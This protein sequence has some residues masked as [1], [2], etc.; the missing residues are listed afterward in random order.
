[1]KCLRKSSF[2]KFLSSLCWNELC[3]KDHWLYGDKPLSCTSCTWRWNWCFSDCSLLQSVQLRWLI[4]KNC[5]CYQGFKNIT[6]CGFF[7]S[8]YIVRG[9]IS[10]QFVWNLSFLL[11]QLLWEKKKKSSWSQIYG[12]FLWVAFNSAL[13]SS[14]GVGVARFLTAWAVPHPPGSSF[15]RTLAEGSFSSTTPVPHPREVSCPANRSP[16][17]FTGLVSLMVPLM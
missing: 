14:D 13:P 10:H 8:L 12:A 5:G 15:S 7:F 9:S 2:P 1:M 4:P 16:V 17:H 11:E 3:S 6:V